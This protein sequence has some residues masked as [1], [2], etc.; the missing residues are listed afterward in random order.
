MKL[1]KRAALLLAML[2]VAVL[3]PLSAIAATASAPGEVTFTKELIASDAANNS[4][5]I[6][7]TARGEPVSSTSSP[8]CSAVLVI[9][10][11]GS[12]RGGRIAAAKNAAKEF[13]K[14]LLEINPDNQI[15]IVTYASSPKTVQGFT[16]SKATLDSK[17]DSLVADGGTHMM[18]GLHLAQQLVAGRQNAHVVLLA[19][20]EPTYGYQPKTSLEV[21]SCWYVGHTT[22]LIA[23]NTE[24]DYSKTCGSGSDTS[25]GETEWWITTTCP[26]CGNKLLPRL[27]KSTEYDLADGV[28]YEAGLVKSSAKLY[29]VGFETS[30]YG[31]TLLNN[32]QN[33]GYYNGTV[34]NL[35]QVFKEMATTIAKPAG[36]NA[37]VTDVMS[38]YVD[39]STVQAPAG[40]SYDQATGKLTWNVGTLTS[41]GASI[42]YT[43]SLKNEYL[44]PEQDTNY[45]L[46]ASATL[47]YTDYN[48]QAASKTAPAPE[49]PVKAAP[50]VTPTPTPE[51]TPTPTPEVT[52]TPTPEVT[53]TPTP[54]V[55]PT[56][57]PEVTPTPTPEV[58]PTPTP[59]V[60]P[61]PTPVVTEVPPQV[62]DPTPVPVEP[63]PT[64]E[65]I[66]DE[67][68]PMVEPEETDGIDEID[69]ID[70]EEIPTDVPKTGDG[71]GSFALVMALIFAGML[72]AVVILRRVV[73]HSDK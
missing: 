41:E 58:T 28:K 55:T 16:S 57:T 37:V 20:G 18:G 47:A 32:I 7:L 35:T 21:T 66:E 13:V 30:G 53:P 26:K 60:T 14:T 45:P 54:E 8:D 11:S 4:Y 71:I 48:S 59:E 73:A 24:F 1:Q 17:I 43:V 3:L 62:F 70:E 40:V 6:K 42:T 68:P 34:S 56:P 49:V 46:N 36:T 39:W 64:P 25:E 72:S 23:S 69:E 2:M 29:T 27:L 33:S 12:M 63:V 44:S 61:T 38:Q 15:A 10:V 67:E 65:E 31:T 9:D 5:A 19:D 51:V 50:I 22:K 52:P